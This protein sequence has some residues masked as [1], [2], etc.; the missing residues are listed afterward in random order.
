VFLARLMVGRVRGS[1]PSER[2]RHLFRPY[3]ERGITTITDQP[4]ELDADPFRRPCLEADTV[5][6]RFRVG[7]AKPHPVDHDFNTT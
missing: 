5:D 3:G 1:A 6:L 4:L 7:L 2:R